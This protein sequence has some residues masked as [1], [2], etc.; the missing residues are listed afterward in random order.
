M[1]DWIRG[2]LSASARVFTAVLPAA[3]ML[4]YFVIGFVVF[5]AVALIRGVP[6]DADM[7]T[8]G[9]SALIGLY[10]RNFFIWVT[11]PL[12]RGVLRSG[13][14]AT[15]ITTLA[16]LFG[17]GA[18]VA[19]AAGRFALGGWLF[20]F[21]G[22]LDALDGR[23]ARI[24]MQATPAGAAIDSVLDRYTDMVML[25]GLAWY[26]RSTW[27]LLPVLAAIL[28]TS[29]VP[30]VRAKSEALKH[31]VRD[32]LMQR[33]E[34]IL[35]LGAA[36]ALSPVFEAVI[37]PTDAH[38]LH[39]LAVI[40]IIFL[41]I[42]SNA[43]ALGRF[44]GL[45]RSLGG[46][47]SRLFVKAGPSMVAAAVATL[48]DYGVVTALIIWGALTLPLATAA[49][50]VAGAILNFWLNRVWTFGSRQAAVPQLERY[51]LVSFVSLLLNAGAVALLSLHWQSHHAWIWWPARAA[52]FVLW[53]LPLQRDYV[54]AAPAAPAPGVVPLL[55]RPGGDG[56]A[57]RGLA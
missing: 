46:M 31:P 51:A 12:W 50:C 7:E 39:W 15:A 16:A 23:I 38:P 26:Y 35:T 24:R 42:S 5:S 29:I 27:V 30:Y 45:V 8:R 34:R 6:R 2:D 10:L 14:P 44:I 47:P 1:L 19:V 25:L 20:L 22:I 32:G 41:A 49:G 9:A 43:T 56:P 18:G 53:N 13:I 54:F 33:P 11:A 55:A 57:S 40:G 21:S 37:F 3:L 4:A 28:G 17:L 52:V 36:V 48:A